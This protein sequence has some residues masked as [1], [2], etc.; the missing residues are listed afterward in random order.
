MTKKPTLFSVAL[1][2]TAKREYNMGRPATKYNK[3]K[4]ILERDGQWELFNHVCMDMSVPSTHIMRAIALM[5]IKV[6]LPTVCRWRKELNYKN[7]LTWA[8]VDAD[9]AYDEVT[10]ILESK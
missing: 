1:S 4:E 10:S 9:M 8:Q 2:Q 5:G 6:T 7:Q 3:L